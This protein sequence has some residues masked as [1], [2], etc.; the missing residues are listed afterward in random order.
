MTRWRR[1]PSSSLTT[2][3]P[4]KRPTTTDR[5]LKST[6]QARQSGCPIS[7]CHAGLVPLTHQPAPCPSTS[8]RKMNNQLCNRSVP[9]RS[10]YDGLS[11]NTIVSTLNMWFVDCSLITCSQN[12]VTV[13]VGL[14]YQPKVSVFGKLGFNISQI[15]PKTQIGLKYVIYNLLI[16]YWLLLLHM[17]FKFSQMWWIVWIVPVFAWNPLWSVWNPAI[18]RFCLFSFL[19]CVF[20]VLFGTTCELVCFTSSCRPL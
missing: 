8:L 20:P 3:H 7:G 5:C 18:V 9:V 17:H 10:K 19:M 1:L 12:T 6:T 11:Q 16:L 15:S 14:T 4:T 13:V 2:L